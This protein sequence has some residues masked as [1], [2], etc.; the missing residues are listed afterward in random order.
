MKVEMNRLRP[1]SRSAKNELTIRSRGA[2][3][4]RERMKRNTERQK[5]CQPKRDPCGTVVH[6][7][8]SK[9]CPDQTNEIQVDREQLASCLHVASNS[10]EDREPYQKTIS[11]MYVL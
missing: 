2:G 4:H 1:V 9:V 6:V 3:C 7:V 11:R 5:S 10:S 8:V